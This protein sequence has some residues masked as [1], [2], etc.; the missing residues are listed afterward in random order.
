MMDTKLVQN[1]E[2]RNKY[3]TSTNIDESTGLYGSYEVKPAVVNPDG[4]PIQFQCGSQF[5]EESPP[6][7]EGSGILY[8]QMSAQ[9]IHITIICHVR[10]MSVLYHS[11]KKL[12]MKNIFLYIKSTACDDEIGWDF[13][14]SFMKTKISF[15]A[16]C[17]EMT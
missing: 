13:I 6:I 9:L 8:T 17:D 15:T 2:D 7:F 16:F 3:I 11:H 12:R 14:Q 5:S 10:L 1:T 4:T